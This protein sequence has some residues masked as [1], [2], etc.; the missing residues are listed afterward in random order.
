M[1]ENYRILYILD[2]KQDGVY[3]QCEFA[4]FCNNEIYPYSH[5]IQN[6]A[7]SEVIL[8]LFHNIKAS[9]FQFWILKQFF[10]LKTNLQ[11]LHGCWFLP[12]Y[13][14]LSM[15][16]TLQCTMGEALLKSG[17]RGIYQNDSLKPHFSESQ[18][19]RQNIYPLSSFTF[20]LCLGTSWT[21]PTA[22]EEFTIESVSIYA[23]G[24][25]DMNEIFRTSWM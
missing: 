3:Y 18:Y 11:W 16:M 20:D 12:M 6:C 5:H 25:K 1:L 8:L 2:T 23:G 24:R 17:N 14:S 22:E 4:R 13:H 9:V 19:F 15:V 7:K 10:V 21:Q